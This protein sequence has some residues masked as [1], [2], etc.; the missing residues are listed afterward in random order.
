MGIPWITSSG[1]VFVVDLLATMTRQRSIITVRFDVRNSCSILHHMSIAAER[2]VRQVTFVA[3]F[4]IPGEDGSSAS[5][6]VK[7]A[8]SVTIH[9]LSGFI[10]IWCGVPGIFIYSYRSGDT[11]N[12]T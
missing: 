1:V 10:A 3:F 4:M 2:S 9:L 6:L 8:T 5:V 12:S 7:S 11:L